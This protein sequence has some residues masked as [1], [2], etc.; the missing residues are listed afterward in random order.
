V[1]YLKCILVGIAAFVVA[2]IIGSAAA[3]AFMVRHEQLARRIFPEQHFDI[4][5]GSRYY[6]NFPLWQIVALG[7]VA[8]AITFA[9]LV[10]RTSATPA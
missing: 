10:R 6:I 3:I 1:I 8:F 7:V 5:I 4:Q 9:W 2:T